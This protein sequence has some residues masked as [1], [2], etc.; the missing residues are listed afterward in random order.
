MMV[1][2]AE[3]LQ[4]PGLRWIFVVV[5]C[6]C[7][8]HHTIIIDAI[9]YDSTVVVAIADVIWG[10]NELTVTVIIFMMLQRLLMAIVNK[11]G[12]LALIKS[13][14]SAIPI[15]TCLILDMLPWFIK[16]LNKIFKAFLW[17]STEVVQGGN[18]LW[19]G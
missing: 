1:S 5:R 14:L 7:R 9:P 8:S 17:T 15:H 6:D 12:H 18:A 11:S 19:H 3:Q 13:T 2:L 10:W 16:A 4:Q